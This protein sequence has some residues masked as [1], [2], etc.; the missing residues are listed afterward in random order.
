MPSTISAH[1]AVEISGWRGGSPPRL[2]GTRM[3][4][5]GMC[6]SSLVARMSIGFVLVTGALSSVWKTV[7]A[8]WRSR[9]Y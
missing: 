6:E 2:S 9:A 3:M 8:L 5:S 7:V 1:S 4:T